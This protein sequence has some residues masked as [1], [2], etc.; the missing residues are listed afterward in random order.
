MVKLVFCGCF[1]LIGCGILTPGDEDFSF[2]RTPYT[3]NEFRLDGYYY[4]VWSKGTNDRNETDLNI[5]FFYR[6]GVVLKGGS[7][8]LSELPKKEEEFK[9]GAYYALV[10]NSKLYWSIFRVD[11]ANY[12]IR[13]RWVNPNWRYEVYRY[14]YEILNDTTIRLFTSEKKDG[15]GYLLENDTLY[16]KAFSPKPDS[17]VSFIP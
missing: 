8:I 11:S 1:F 4:Q 5:F 9:N 15:S 12:I 10:R 13:E 16:F 3:G 2:E 7:C 17:V 6:N 14:K